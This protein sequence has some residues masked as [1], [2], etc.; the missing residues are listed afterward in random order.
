M[1]DWETKDIVW[2]ILKLMGYNKL[3]EDASKGNNINSYIRY[4]KFKVKKY[5][6]IK[7]LVNY[8]L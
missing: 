8:F 4:I 6:N 3:S 7:D 1:N 5:S 2:S